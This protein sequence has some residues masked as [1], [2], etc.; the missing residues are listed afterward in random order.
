MAA[1]PSKGYRAGKPINPA[2]PLGCFVQRCNGTG[3]SIL[4]LYIP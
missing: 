2:R 3:W 4:L 1:G